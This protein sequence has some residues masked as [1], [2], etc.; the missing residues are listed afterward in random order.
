MR[1]DGFGFAFGKILMIA[2]I[3]VMNLVEDSI[4]Q[5]SFR[6]LRCMIKHEPTKA[7]IKGWL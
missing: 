1:K 2:L 6:T 7:E 4:A 3:I 5:S